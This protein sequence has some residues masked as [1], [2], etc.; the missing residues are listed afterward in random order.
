VLAFYY[1]TNFAGTVTGY[2]DHIG[3]NTGVGGSK[4]ISFEPGDAEA[5]RITAAGNV[6]IGTT[7]PTINGGGLHV[8]GSGQK[9]IRISGNSSNSYSVEIGCDA[10]KMSYIQTVGTA[11]RGLQLYTGNA[12]T[13]VMTLTGSNVGIGTTSPSN[14]LTINNNSDQ[15]RLETSSGPTSYYSVISAMYDSSHPFGIYVA[16]NSLGTA[17]YMGVYADG[18]GFNNRV[19]FP[20]GNV[21]IGTT[22]PGGKLH[23]VGSS[24]ISASAN[25]T[26]VKFE[27]GGGNGLAF[28]TIDSTSTYASWIQSGYVLSFSTA[29]YNLLLQPLGGNVIVGKSA[30][31]G[32]GEVNTLQLKSLLVFGSDNTGS[33]SNRNWNIGTNGS[34][35]GNMDWTVGSTNTGWPNF[36]YRLQLTS[37]GSLNNTTGTYGTISDLRLKENISDARNYLDDLLKLRVVKYSLKEESSDFATK[38]GFIAQEVEQVFPN[39]V[40]QSDI[41]YDGGDGIR[42]V[43]TSILIP[44]LLKSIQELSANVKTLEAKVQIL[45][46]K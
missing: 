6:G 46:S 40:D 29:T 12:S 3:L 31:Y 9:G 13:I 33:A 27:G 37:S 41:S 36:A 15:L 17:E 25:T 8:Y 20:T 22:N 32:V 7:S 21:G 34:A 35:A 39:L 14:K 10:T 23:V 45:E 38:I 28:G 42:S 24:Y 43:K 1:C 19:S 16:N 26:N 30:G 44:M 18:G 2:S 5:M 4:Y 11:D